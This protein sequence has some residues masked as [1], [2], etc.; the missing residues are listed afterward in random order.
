MNSVT[1]I[2]RLTK[3]V[4][5]RETAGG[6]KVASVNIAIDRHD[7]DNNA[8][9]PQVAIFGKTAENLA[10]YCGKGSLVGIQGRL[11]TGKYTDKDG[12]TQYTTNVVA[13]RVE[14]LSRRGNDEAY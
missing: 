10:Q 1:L 3:D 12:K 4:E 14:F 2:G 7:K 9:F 13:D 5:L 6:T 8:D 11:Q